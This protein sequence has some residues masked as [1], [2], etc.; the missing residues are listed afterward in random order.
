MSES[1]H[2]T[3]VFNDVLLFQCEQ[4]WETSTGE[5]SYNLKC[6]SHEKLDHQGV[7]LKTYVVKNQK[8]L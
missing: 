8:T 5:K 3:P 1:K 6:V 4:G 2:S 7:C